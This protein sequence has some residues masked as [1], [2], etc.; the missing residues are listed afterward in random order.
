[1]TP[2]TFKEL[3]DF[4]K[5]CRDM[6]PHLA[7]VPQ[8]ELNALLKSLYEAAKWKTKLERWRD[9]AQDQLTINRKARISMSQAR[10]L[11][12]QAL[13]ILRKAVVQNWEELSEIEGS[14]SIG[15]EDEPRTFKN[16]IQ[17]LKDAVECA[18]NWQLA[19]A[20][21]IHPHLRSTAEKQ[22]A[23]QKLSGGRGIVAGTILPHDYPARPRSPA[24]AHWFI[25]AAAEC[26][27]KYRTGT[28]KKIPR[29]DKIIS[30]LFQVAFGDHGRND[31]NIRTELQRQER[32]GMPVYSPSLLLPE[33]RQRSDLGQKSIRN[34]SR[35]AKIYGQERT[36]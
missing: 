2:K 22:Q 20:G 13:K 6:K 5:F 25:G 35:R 7:L 36:T 17:Y 33:K 27:D 9:S 23:Q 26:L 16:T 18:D 30:M 14:I 31:E 8:S 34:R 4:E 11:L 12:D 32:I 29:Y 21:L 24:I 3:A 1:M 19:Y 10:K 28:G 15:F